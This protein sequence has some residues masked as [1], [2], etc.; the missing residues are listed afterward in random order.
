M[1]NRAP[2][3]STENNSGRILENYPAISRWQALDDVLLGKRVRTLLDRDF[4]DQAGPPFVWPHIYQRFKI[5][6][7]GAF[8]DR[9]NL[10]LPALRSHSRASIRL[11]AAQ[12]AIPVLCNFHAVPVTCAPVHEPRR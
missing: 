6:N 1:P 7:I 9:R 4:L 8:H 10:S 11:N 12:D 5:P 2:I 3:S